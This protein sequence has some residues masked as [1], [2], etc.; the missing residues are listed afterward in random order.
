MKPKI[1][2]WLRELL[3]LRGTPW[4]RWHPQIALRYLP[5]V[6]WIHQKSKISIL[7]VGSGGLGIVPYLKQPVTGVDLEFKP[8]IHPLLTPVRGNATKLEFKDDS[9]DVIICMDMLEHV[10]ERKRLKAVMEMVRIA[11]KGVV[12]GVPCGKLAEEQD[13]KLREQ[14]RRPHGAEFSF[15]K[16]QVKHGLPKETDLLHYIKVASKKSRKP[17]SITVCGNLNLSLR[18]FL[19]RGWMSESLIT[20]LIFR[21]VFLLLVPFFRLLDRPPYYRQ[22]FFV[23]LL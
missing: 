18:S 3:A 8:P 23:K 17:V 21:K 20:N 12:I 15:L 5:V 4:Y 19:M 6:E 2:V 13:K 10:E 14:Y 22:L 11:K 16:E 1:K 9:F 7:E